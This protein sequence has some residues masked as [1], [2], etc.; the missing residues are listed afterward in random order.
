MAKK[1]IET[2]LTWQN[3][4]CLA[5]LGIAVLVAP[6]T[7]GERLPIIGTESYLVDPAESVQFEEGH[8]V[9]LG[10]WIGSFMSDDPSSPLHH[11]SI[12]CVGMVDALADGSW[13][14]SGYCMN[15]DLE[16]DQWVGKWENSSAA[17]GVATYTVIGVSGKFAGATG[18]GTSSCTELAQGPKSRLVCEQNGEMILK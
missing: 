2:Q 4:V 10:R 14:A 13:G 15:T 12:D 9:I 6:A 3:I 18:G 8:M 17:D 1:S 11:D 5:I 7:A 16:A